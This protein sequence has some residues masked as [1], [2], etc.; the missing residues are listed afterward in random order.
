MPMR[1]RIETEDH[2]MNGEFELA[3]E[4]VIRA[5][6]QTLW[7]IWTE[8]TEEWFAPRPWKT[9]VIEYDLRPGGRCAITM[10]G[11]DGAETPPMEGVFLEVVEHERIVTTDAFAAGWVPQKPFMVAVTTFTDLG[12]GTTLYRAAARHWDAETM[13]Q[14]EAMGFTTGWGTV[15]DQLA[16]LAEAA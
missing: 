1:T 4:R 13:A 16:E 15:A 3:I 10:T 14:H 7:T 12:D 5:S 11:P 9:R 6:P 8:R 2:G